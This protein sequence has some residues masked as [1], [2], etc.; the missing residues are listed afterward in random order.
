MVADGN[1]GHAPIIYIY[2][3]LMNNEF[4]EIQTDKNDRIIYL[5]PR[6]DIHIY[7]TYVYA[8]R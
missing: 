6:Y 3:L 2:G 1:E 7:V 8:K 4:I 5:L